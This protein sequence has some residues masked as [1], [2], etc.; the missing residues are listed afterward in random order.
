MNLTAY[1]K[2]EINQ[3]GRRRLKEKGVEKKC[4]EK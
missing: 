3:Q 4:E 1:K 2:R